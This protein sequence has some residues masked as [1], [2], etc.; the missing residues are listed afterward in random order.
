MKIK[1]RHH[2]HRS[3]FVPAVVAASAFV[4]CTLV[5]NFALAASSATPALD[6]RS[7]VQPTKPK[8]KA[9]RPNWMRTTASMTVNPNASYLSST[10][11]RKDRTFSD[12]LFESRS[13]LSIRS[14]LEQRVKRYDA[15]AN[16]GLTTPF[17]EQTHANEMSAFAKDSV[18]SVGKQYLKKSYLN[19]AEKH[20]IN[21][22]PD[23]VKE[24]VAA[25]FFLAAASTGRALN[26]R[27]GDEL[28][29]QSRTNVRSREASLSM[30]IPGWSSTFGYSHDGGGMNASISKEI[31]KNLSAVAGSGNENSLQLQYGLSF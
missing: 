26:V 20:A 3:A 23:G 4:F 13:C 10:A 28:R 17:D 2:S 27:M 24:P 1:G 11:I 7:V 22:T 6:S 30:L 19:P 5:P 15:R 18:N 21:S 31:D 14:D 8:R 9:L 12:E 25:A 29:L 16:A